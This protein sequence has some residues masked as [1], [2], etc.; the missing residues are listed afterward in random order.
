M[1]LLVRVQIP[2]VAVK[3]VIKMREYDLEKQRIKIG[4][5]KATSEII[6]LD[7]LIFIKIPNE[8]IEKP[9]QKYN[10]RKD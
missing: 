5:D 7:N 1:D 9:K 8:F 2:A 4:F 6:Y 10:F 3:E